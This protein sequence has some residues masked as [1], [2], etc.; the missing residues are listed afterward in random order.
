MSNIKFNESLRDK[1]GKYNS[2]KYSRVSPKQFQE[3]FEKLVKVYES[4]RI[5]RESNKI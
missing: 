1:L 2:I 3:M 5:E 4:K